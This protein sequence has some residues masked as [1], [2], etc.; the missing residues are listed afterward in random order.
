MICFVLG[1]RALRASR[2]KRDNEPN[3]RV[4]TP[5]QNSNPTSKLQGNPGRRGGLKG[6]ANPAPQY[7]DYTQ[8]N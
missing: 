3:A 5:T 8:R 4:A 1:R 7:G 2:D 6:G